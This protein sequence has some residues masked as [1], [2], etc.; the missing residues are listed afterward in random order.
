M[1]CRTKLNREVRQLEF[2]LF[3]DQLKSLGKRVSMLESNI[4]TEEATK[5]SLIMPFFQVLGYDI[6]NPMEFVPEFTADVGIKKGEKV[7]YAIQSDGSPMILIE[8]KSIKEELTK[9][10]S[11]LFRYFATT[12]SKFGILTNGR[13]YK[14]YTDLDEPNKMDSSPFLVV[15]ITKL[16]ENQ[17]PEIAKF[18]KDNFDVDKITSSASELKYLNSL[19][20]FL[21]QQ[22]D[23]PDESFVKYIVGEIYEGMKTKNTLE[24]FQ[25]I[26]KKGLSH[27]INDKVNEKLSA[28]L[29]TSVNAAKEENEPSPPVEQKTEAEIITT[30]EELEA[31]AT[32]KVVLKDTVAAERIFYRDNQS[33][34]NILLD[35]NIRRWILRVYTNNK[36]TNNNKIKLVFNDTD[37]QNERTTLEVSNIIEIANHSKK[38]IETVRRL[39]K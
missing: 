13:I 38:L 22:F 5:T 17:I 19:K 14:F 3:S 33:Y 26:I 20:Q 8:A 39:D 36:Y 31:Y 21:N 6:F 15:D 32:V 30:Q 23:N 34:F 37:V 25:P 16:K 35:D 9:H 4:E 11:Q 2:E 24:K 7:D 27:F 12:T 10:D 18:H 1:I 28:A 29:N